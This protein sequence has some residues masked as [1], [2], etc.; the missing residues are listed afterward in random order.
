MLSKKKAGKGSSYSLGEDSYEAVCSMRKKLQKKMHPDTKHEVLLVTAPI[1]KDP[2]RPEGEGGVWDIL[3]EDETECKNPIPLF[4]SQTRIV[5]EHSFYPIQESQHSQYDELSRINTIELLRS[6]KEEIDQLKEQLSWKKKFEERPREFQPKLSGIE[7]QTKKALHYEKGRTEKRTQVSNE[8][9]LIV[10]ALY[11]GKIMVLNPF[12]STHQVE[13][14]FISLFT[15]LREENII[16]DEQIKSN[17]AR[18]AIKVHMGVNLGD[19]GFSQ[20]SGV[21]G[22]SVF[23]NF[24]LIFLISLKL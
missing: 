23:G 2:P 4:N 10:K 18:E 9:G 3:L 13:R 16:Y 1:A 15:F 12:P 8:V 22:K 24:G 19:D 11:Y 20:I 7:V 6:Q 17:Q 5:P 14:A 21:V